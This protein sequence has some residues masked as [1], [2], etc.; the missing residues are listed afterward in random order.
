MLREG[1]QRIRHLLRFALLPYCFVK[2]VNWK[3]CPRTRLQVAGD[4]LYIFFKLRTFP[5]HYS[6]CRLW[7]HPRKEWPRFYGSNYNPFQRERLRREVHPLTLERAFQ[8]KDICDALC[9][10]M[11]LPMPRELGAINPGDDCALALGAML[12]AN[13]G[14]PLI[15]K[16]VNGHAGLGIVRVH[17]VGSDVLLRTRSDDIP[18]SRFDPPERMIVQRILAQHPALS[19]IAPSSVNTLRLLTMLDKRGEFSIVGASMRFGVGSAFIDNWSAG[20]VAVGV[21]HETGRLM[22][23]GFDKLGKAYESHPV[24]QVVFD[25]LEIPLWGEAIALGAHV[26]RCFQFFRLLGMDIAFTPEGPVLIEI[27]NDAD[28]VFQEQTSGPLFGSKRTWELFKEY[29]L[30][31]NDAQK[32]LKFA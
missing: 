21:H 16:P 31:Y 12:D 32:G 7:E 27:N 14:E 23:V 28:I 19:R 3:E 30:L 15:A 22:R 5:D 26:Q 9:R 8:R 4:L 13:Q 1:N 17:R 29:D 20:G 10:E 18:A 24:S 25:Q 11:G 2:L 6:A